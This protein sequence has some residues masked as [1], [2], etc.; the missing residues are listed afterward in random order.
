MVEQ[1]ETVPFFKVF[2]KKPLCMSFACI[3]LHTMCM[4]CLPGPEEG[5]WSS[6]TVVIDSCGMPWGML[7]AKPRSFERAATGH[8]SWGI[9]QPCP[10]FLVTVIFPSSVKGLLGG[11]CATK[12]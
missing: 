3:C 11:I 5:V 4:Q 9:S 6:G 10:R 2:F 8:N 1:L 12:S 7:E